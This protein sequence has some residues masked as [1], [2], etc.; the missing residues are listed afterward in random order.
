MCQQ[1]LTSFLIFYPSMF[2]QWNIKHR[3]VEAD[4]LIF[5]ETGRENLDG[6]EFHPFPSSKA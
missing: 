2:P 4:W 5:V 3:K 1:R 6:S